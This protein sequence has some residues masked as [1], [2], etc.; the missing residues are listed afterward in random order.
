MT[1]TWRTRVRPKMLGE[2]AQ[3]FMTGRRRSCRWTPGRPPRRRRPRQSVVEA[4]DLPRRAA[5]RQPS[6]SGRHLPAAA[7]ATRHHGLDRAVPAGRGAAAGRRRGVRAARARGRGRDRRASAAQAGTLRRH[8]VRR[9]A[10]GPLPRRRRGGRL[11]RAARVRRPQLRDHRPPRRGA[12]PGRRAPAHGGRPGAARAAARRRCSTPSSTRV[13]DGYAPV[14][15]GLQNDIDEIETEVFRGDPSVS[16]RIYELSREVIEFQR[17]TRPLLRI[18]DGLAAGFDK[19]GIDEEL[20]RYLRDVADH[21]T[22]V[23]RAGR[24][25][26]ADCSPTSSPSTPPWSRRRRTRR[27][28]AS[29]RPATPRT[30]RSRRS[31]P[32]RPSCSRPPSI[33]T[34]YGMNFDHMPELH[35]SAA[36]RSRSR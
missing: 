28:S 32:G 31:P 30:R 8:P 14:V 29:P 11:R 25:L 36:T 33:G 23:S 3:P 5:R 21:A 6:H 9:P 27:S 10:G 35:W 19:Y 16:R 18:L 20:R 2:P 4:G 24:R 17:A 26:P 15:A 13:V 12:R 22:T 1:D 34:V 7:R